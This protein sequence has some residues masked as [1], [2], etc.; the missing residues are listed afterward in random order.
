METVGCYYMWGSVCLL[1]HRISDLEAADL[2]KMT[3]NFILK[4]YTELSCLTSEQIPPFGGHIV[5]KKPIPL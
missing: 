3:G 2:T 4:G 1:V 5:S